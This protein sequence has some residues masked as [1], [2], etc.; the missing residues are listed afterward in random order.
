MS[1]TAALLTAA[2]GVP[3]VSCGDQGHDADI[4]PQLGR[5]CFD[6]HLDALPPGAQYEGIERAGDGRLTIRIM[7]GVTVRTLDCAIGAQGTVR[8]ETST[9][10]SP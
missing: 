5:A 9:M 8:A 3:L 1:R 10:P 6:A 4:D 7:D 2:L